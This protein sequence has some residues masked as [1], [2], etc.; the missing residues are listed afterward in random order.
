MEVKTSPVFCFRLTFEAVALVCS[1][2]C[3]TIRYILHSL[4]HSYKLTNEG[5]IGAGGYN[6]ITKNPQ[7]V[8]CVTKLGR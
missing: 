2:W 7:L 3:E 8:V 5:P 4:A 6:M 1:D